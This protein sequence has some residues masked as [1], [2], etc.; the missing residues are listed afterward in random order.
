MKSLQII[1]AIAVIAVSTSANASEPKDNNT[2]A[3]QAQAFT[4]LTA[5][6][7]VAR[8]A[9]F[10]TAQKEAF[11][12]HQEAIKNMQTQ[13]PATPAQNTMPA[14]MQARRDAFMKQI[15]ERR[16]ANDKRRQEMPAD[17]QARRDAFRDAAE[18]RREEMMKKYN[19]SRSSE[20]TAENS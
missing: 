20:D 10:E 8:R 18:K 17:M 14:D 19:E 15:E 16:A 12:R 9:N 1:A 2:N 7:M 3:Y 6:E 4:P 11:E 5:E 13:A